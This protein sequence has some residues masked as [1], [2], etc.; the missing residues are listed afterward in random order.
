MSIAKTKVFLSSR[1]KEN[2]NLINCK[3]HVKIMA[4]NIQELRYNFDLSTNVNLSSVIW[5]ILEYHITSDATIHFIFEEFNLERLN[6]AEAR[7]LKEIFDGDKYPAIKDSVVMILAQSLEK[8]RYVGKGNKT[9]FSHQQ[10]LYKL[11]GMHE[12]ELTKSMRTTT[13]INKLVVA[14]QRVIEQGKTKQVLASS[15]FR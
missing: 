12:E 10:Y 13:S 15:K 11:T 6:D 14:A 7:T 4:L 2:A 8:R 5:S 1:M 9:L 3:S